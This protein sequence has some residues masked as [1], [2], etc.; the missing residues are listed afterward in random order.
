MLG[1]MGSVPMP[2]DWAL[3]TV[4]LPMCG[5]TWGDAALSFVAMW[6]AMMTPMMLAVA[7]P[8]LWRA[9]SGVRIAM[10]ATSYAL[11]WTALG[12]LV[13]LAGATVAQAAWQ[14]AALARVVPLCAGAALVL[15]GAF[16]FSALKAR[17][18]DACTPAS[19]EV[20]TRRSGLRASW[21]HG[22]GLA[23]HCIAAC[24]GFTIALL[25]IG[26]T[27][28]WTML[29]LGAAAAMERWTPHARHVA[30]ATGV[31]GVL[32]GATLLAHGAWPA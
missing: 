24:A 4:W 8:A 29:V 17:W 12:A 10:A 23:L 32:A 6:G 14:F 20:A 5:Q 25:A 22:Q 31:L 27:Q 28:P 7:A 26:V 1:A 13:F 15:A 21:R 9:G 18:L 2:G 16:Q 3:S 30:A 11:W 19:A